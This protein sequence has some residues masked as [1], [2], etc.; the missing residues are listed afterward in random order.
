MRAIVMTSAGGPEVLV[1]RDMPAPTPAAGQVLIE[2]GAIGV[3][4]AE[5]Q[6]RS[7]MF[8][9]PTALPDVFG[10]EVAGTVTGVGPG[11]DPGLIGARVIATTDGTG[12]YA[13]QVVVAAAAAVVV[14]DDLSL[15]DAVAVA[16]PGAVALT[17]LRT[18]AMR[19][20]ETVLVEA[21]STGVGAYLT[22]MAKEFGAARVIA[23]AGTD[24]KCE[25]ARSLGADGVSVHSAPGWQDAVRDTLGDTTLDVVFES[26]GGA[27][28]AGLLDAMTPLTG[29]MLFY[30]MLSGRPAAVTSQDLVLRGLTLVGC[31]GPAWLGRVADARAEILD[32]AVAGTLV[33][34]IDSVIP[35][36]QA[37]LAH[38]KIEQRKNSGKLILDPTA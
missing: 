6:L 5:T 22:Q 20:H 18:A 38:E 24:E 8:P 33:P 17:L 14:P 37:H 2:A 21:A 1:E 26:I 19:G 12:A 27:S 7:G 13:E 25:R 31:G 11:V 15:H 32:R 30:G 3:H 35:L 28:A 10:G 34:L 4:F 29:R 16:V 36:G 9:S 23:T